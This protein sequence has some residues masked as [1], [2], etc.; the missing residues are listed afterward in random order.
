MLRYQGRWRD[1][2]IIGMS[3]ESR[4][5]VW[6]RRLAFCRRE[7]SSMVLRSATVMLYENPQ[8]QGLETVSI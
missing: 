4:M 5:P 1:M 7:K 3:L 6:G 8:T 2:G